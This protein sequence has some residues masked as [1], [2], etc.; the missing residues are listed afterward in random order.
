[1]QEQQ[2][3]INEAVRLQQQIDY[4]EG[5][6]KKYLTKEAITRY[7]NV[8]SAH[9]ETAIQ[10]LSLLAQS[11]Q[12]GNIKEKITDEQFKSLLIQIT[13]KKEFRLLK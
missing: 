9:P 8:K 11:L 5:L 13:Q 6:V 7:Y 2:N 4:L 12:Y 10:V 1:M 3:N